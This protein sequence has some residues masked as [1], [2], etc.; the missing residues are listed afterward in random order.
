MWVIAAMLEE[1][2]IDHRISELPFTFIHKYVHLPFSHLFQTSHCSWSQGSQTVHESWNLQHGSPS[3]LSGHW[4]VPAAAEVE[5]KQQKCSFLLFF[6]ISQ[7]LYYVGKVN[8]QFGTFDQLHL[9]TICTVK[10]QPL[11]MVVEYLGFV[12]VHSW[13]VW[14][15]WQKCKWQIFLY[16][17]LSSW[18]NGT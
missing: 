10:K 17:V 6:F 4:S 11:V 13:L 1:E 15:L 14:N 7:C 9:S 3:I 18:S 12:Y 16:F 2:K 5:Q 8:M